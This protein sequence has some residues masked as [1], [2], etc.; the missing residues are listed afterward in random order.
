MG[1]THIMDDD[2]WTEQRMDV[3]LQR[4]VEK[5]KAGDQVELQQMMA[6]MQAQQQAQQQGQGQPG[7]PAQEGQG[8]PPEVMAAMQQQAQAQQQGKVTDQQASGAYPPGGI[9]PGMPLQG[10]LP[11]GQ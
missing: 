1:Q 6:A 7:Q 11:A 2:V 10:P 4:L 3:E 9:Q 8:M 5:L